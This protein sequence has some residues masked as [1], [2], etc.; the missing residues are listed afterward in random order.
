MKILLIFSFLFSSFDSIASDDEYLNKVVVTGTSIPVNITEFP[1]DVTVIDHQYIESSHARDV[2][3]L[4]KEVPGVFVDQAGGR[5]GVSSIYLRGAD[6]NFTL[7]L[8]DGVR[9]N[10][11]NN[12]RGGSFN[13]S[14]FT[15][16]RSRS[17]IS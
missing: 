15:G 2:S 8:L 1:S 11:P 14:T 13:L 6:P 4:L 9:L 3:E 16:S 17:I 5:G 7:I 10:D 12:S